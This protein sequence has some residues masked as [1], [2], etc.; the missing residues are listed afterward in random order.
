MCTE[1]HATLVPGRS[2]K[3]RT[4]TAHSGGGTEPRG[5]QSVEND[6]ETRAAFV[7]AAAHMFDHRRAWAAA[8]IGA[9]VSMTK[10]GHNPF[11]GVVDDRTADGIVL[12]VLS[13][14]GIR[15]LFHIEDGFTLSPE[16]G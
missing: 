4:P 12:W 2:R 10:H 14:T 15:K 13:A 5:N 9:E 6:Q 3:R 7:A 16:K 8:G 11:L 1:S